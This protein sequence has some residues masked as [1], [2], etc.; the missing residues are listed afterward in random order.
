MAI[1]HPVVETVPPA[2]LNSGSP[3]LAEIAAL[4]EDIALQERSVDALAALER[5]KPGSSMQSESQL[6]GKQEALVD[7]KRHLQML[8]EGVAMEVLTRPKVEDEGKYIQATEWVLRETSRVNDVL[9]A[10]H[11]LRQRVP[12]SERARAVYERER[13]AMLM[14]RDRF[15]DMSKKIPVDSPIRAMTVDREGEIQEL[16]VGMLGRDAE[17]YPTTAKYSEPLDQDFVAAEEAPKMPLELYDEEVRKMQVVVAGLESYFE[18]LSR[19]N[20]LDGATLQDLHRQLDDVQEQLQTLDEKSAD[21][22]ASRERRSLMKM[23][24]DLRAQYPATM[25]PAS[26]ATLSSVRGKHAVATVKYA[27]IQHRLSSNGRRAMRTRLASLGA[28]VRQAEDEAWLRL[29]SANLVPT[30]PPPE[31]PA[32]SAGRPA[33]SDEQVKLSI[34]LAVARASTA[35]PVIAAVA[36]AP[37]VRRRGILGA[38]GDAFRLK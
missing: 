7:K 22:S 33:S 10:L 18:L 13:D 25:R 21:P 14:M 11:E 24:N 27:A 20:K 29:H 5:S 2:P 1:E 19:K 4:E 15:E 32:S 26:P 3:E 16:F 35:A 28:M 9:E 38:L 23:V 12:E 6:R 30:P 8:K 31:P 36:H 17:R 34:R 37:A